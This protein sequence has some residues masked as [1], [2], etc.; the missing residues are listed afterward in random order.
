[1]KTARRKLPTKT[2]LQ[3]S[4]NDFPPLPGPSGGS[5]LYAEQLRKISLNSPTK[6]SLNPPKQY[7]IPDTNV[8]MLH[9]KVIMEIV[10]KEKDK[11]VYIP[12]TVRQE[13]DNLKNSD[14][15]KTQKLAVEAN[16][17]MKYAHVAYHQKDR[18]IQQSGEHAFEANKGTIPITNND[19]KII[20]CCMQLKKEGKIVTLYTKDN[21]M[22]CAARSYGIDP[23]P[24]VT[25]E[26]LQASRTGM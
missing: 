6:K 19:D 10:E 3:A 11:I 18:I 24:P 14:N 7:I 26:A 25:Q 9:L 2:D 5:P 21:N 20:A 22:Y 17:F 8:M 1:M 15:A 4:S 12:D 23:H 13:L 16:R